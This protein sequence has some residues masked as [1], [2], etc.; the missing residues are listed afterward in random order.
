MKGIWREIKKSKEKFEK[1]RPVDAAWKTV[2]TISMASN[3][4]ADEAH[5]E[6]AI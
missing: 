4:V 1:W 5:D 6:E 3:P 2:L